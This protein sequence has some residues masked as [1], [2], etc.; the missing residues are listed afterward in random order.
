MTE[1]VRRL[2]AM[3]LQLLPVEVPPVEIKTPTSRILSSQVVSAFIAAAGD[4][5]ETVGRVNE[6]PSEFISIV[7]FQLPYALLRARGLFM[8]DANRNPA[9]YGENLGRGRVAFLSTLYCPEL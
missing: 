8:R 6:Q 9:D 2:R 1:L 3:V 7:L 5:V 4:F